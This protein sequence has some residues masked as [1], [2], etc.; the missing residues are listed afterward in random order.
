MS[1]FNIDEFEDEQVFDLV[2]LGKS[3]KLCDV[4]ILEEI[5]EGSR[6]KLFCKTYWVNKSGEE[7]PMMIYKNIHCTINGNIY[8]CISSTTKTDE[9]P[10][11]TIL[12]LIDDKDSCD[13]TFYDGKCSVGCGK[14]DIINHSTIYSE[15][16]RLI[17]KVYDDTK[18]FK[19][20]YKLAKEWHSFQNF[21]EWYEDSKP[22]HSKDS[23]NRFGS[24][25]L[26]YDLE[27]KREGE[28]G[29]FTCMFIQKYIMK[30]CELYKYTL[31]NDNVYSWN[32]NFAK[33]IK[34]K[35]NKYGVRYYDYEKNKPGSLGDFS[36]LKEAREVYLVYMI[37]KRI[38]ILNY[39]KGLQN[40]L[41]LPLITEIE[42]V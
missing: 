11:N 30:F 1:D 25:I 41:Y 37:N 42:N 5:Q 31:E 34:E 27:H 18:R 32:M 8:K 36:S 24:Y 39:L 21:A 7:I 23:V 33:K 4:M 6:T 22:K 29:P 16:K 28:I 3:R 20:F 2:I 35:T 19:T 14:Y 26:V 15:W 40:N 9:K 10:F 13:K 38:E 12:E 17:D